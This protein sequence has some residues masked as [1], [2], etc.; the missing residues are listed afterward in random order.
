[1][2]I[3]VDMIATGRCCDGEASNRSRMRRNRALAKSR[4][5]GKTE[6]DG[7]SSAAIRNN[8]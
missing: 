5:D 8:L 1:M 4:L 2:A 3:E 7:Q 6:T